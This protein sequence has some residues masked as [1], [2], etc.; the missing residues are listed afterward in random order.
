MASPKVP[1][2][3]SFFSLLYCSEFHLSCQSNPIN[4]LGHWITATHLS[5]FAYQLRY[6]S[7]K[8]SIN[9]ASGAFADFA[10][11]SQIA[12]WASIYDR[13]NAS[14][15]KVI[16]SEFIRNA[17]IDFDEYYSSLTGTR[18]TSYY[19]FVCSFETRCF[20]NSKQQKFPSLL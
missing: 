8:T 12:S 3:F 15:F 16:N 10:S 6:A 2:T 5:N 18:L 1:A 13:Q 14:Q 7:Y 4:T 17:N 20:V 9:H 11:N 19:H